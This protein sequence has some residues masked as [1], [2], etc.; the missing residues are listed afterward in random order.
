MEEQV[1]IL[2]SSGFKY[3]RGLRR[4]SQEGRSI[5]SFVFCVWMLW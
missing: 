2:G 4:V 5:P 3:Q 1:R